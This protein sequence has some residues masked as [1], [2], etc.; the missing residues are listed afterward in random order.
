MIIKRASPAISRTDEEWLTMPKLLKQIVQFMLNICIPPGS[1]NL[2]Y[3]PGK[4]Y[5]CDQPQ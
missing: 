3:V 1:L 4:G 5:L 2:G